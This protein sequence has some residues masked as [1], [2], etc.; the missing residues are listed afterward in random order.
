M[1]F[2]KPVSCI[3]ILQDLTLATLLARPLALYDESDLVKETALSK[4]NYGSVRR[5]YLVC[6]QDNTLIQGF[7]EWMIENN[8]VDEAKTISCADHMPMFSKSHELCVH[9]QDFAQKY[10]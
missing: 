7:Q 2:Q 8:P 10:C 5:V 4:Q 6:D 1:G 9:L 3:N